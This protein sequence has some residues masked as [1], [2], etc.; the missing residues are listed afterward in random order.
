M[1]AEERID[2]FLSEFKELEKELVHISRLKDDYVSFSRALNQ[3]YYNR[4]HPIIAQRDNYDLLKTAS[5]LRNILSHENDICAPTEVFLRKFRCLCQAISSPLSCY[6]VCTRDVDV[7]H[8]RTRIFEALRLMQEKGITHLPILDAT[9]IVVGVFS[10]STLSDCLLFGQKT[11]F[12]ETDSMVDIR[13]EIGLSCHSNECFFF[14]SRRM[15]VLTAFQLILKKKAHEKAV[16]LLL[17][18]ENGKP[19]E[20]L[21]GV[22]TMTDLAKYQLADMYAP[23]AKK[24]SGRS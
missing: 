19:D 8:E 14:V 20:R 2:S 4:L 24:S 11:S 3:I 15:N 17:V 23:K 10:R 12:E 18:T 21:L 13:D 7:G 1:R 16:G 9:G 5:D 22:I 6:D